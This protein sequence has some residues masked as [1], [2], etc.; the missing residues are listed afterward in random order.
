[1]PRDILRVG[2]PLPTESF[3]RSQ[4]PVCRSIPLITPFREMRRTRWPTP[5]SVFTHPVK[6][7]SAMPFPMPHPRRFCRLCPCCS[8]LPG[9]ASSCWPVLAQQAHQFTPITHHF[10]KLLISISINIV[11]P[12][13]TSQQ[14]HQF[15][16]ITHHFDKD[17][18]SI[19][20]IKPLLAWLHC[21]RSRHGWSRCA[22]NFTL[23]NIP[24]R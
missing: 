20:S 17:L 19:S 9:R 24:G 6:R 16:L 23:K 4:H 15:T 2:D 3:H 13:P 7:R 14:A 22:L 11:S 21:H 1:M 18:I 10:D 5:L 12:A 8:F